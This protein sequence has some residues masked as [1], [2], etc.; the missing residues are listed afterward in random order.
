M[1]HM[2]QVS[3]HIGYMPQIYRLTNTDSTLHLLL[4]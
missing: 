1:P 2:T 3:R 4:R